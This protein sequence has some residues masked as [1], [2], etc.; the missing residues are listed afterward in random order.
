MYFGTRTSTKISSSPSA[1]VKRSWKKSAATTRRCPPGPAITNS[2]SRATIGAGRSPAGSA[3]AQAPPMVPRCRT[4]GSATVSTH[5]AIS[6][7]CSATN[8][9]PTT[10]KYGVIAPMTIASPSSRTPLSES[11]LAKSISSS[12]AASRSFITG[13]RLCPPAMILASSPPSASSC[14][15]SSRLVGAL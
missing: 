10:S 1:V 13:S 9:S 14:S 5:L 11:I 15:A 2:A 12:G 4:C 7:A 6:D 3:C 8:G